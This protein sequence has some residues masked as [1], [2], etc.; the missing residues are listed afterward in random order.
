[1]Y[2]VHVDVYCLL[3]MNL[4]RIPPSALLFIPSVAKEVYKLHHFNAICLILRPKNHFSLDFVLPMHIKYKLHVILPSAIFFTYDLIN[5]RMFPKR[6]YICYVQFQ[7]G[8]T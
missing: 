4:Y 7:I 8:T 2:E 5:V 3:L 1:M 6:T